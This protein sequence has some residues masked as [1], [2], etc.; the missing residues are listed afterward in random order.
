MKT[1]DITVER[2]KKYLSE[3]KRFDGRGPEDF[4]EI[5]VETGVAK[6][7]EGSARVKIGKTEVL[8]GIKMNIGEPYPD[9]QDQGN[10][11]ATVELTPLSSNRYELGPPKIGAIER[12]VSDY[13]PCPGQGVDARYSTD[14][15]RRSNCQ[16]VPPKRPAD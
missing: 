7:A 12:K 1:P 15:A 9:S 16:P 3:G 4:R 6:K 2:I 14:N 5:I 13:R 8:V 11:M 10:M